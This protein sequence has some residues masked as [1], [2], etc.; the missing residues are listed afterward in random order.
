MHQLSDPMAVADAVAVPTL[1]INSRDDPICADESID[2]GLLR[3]PRF[4]HATTRRGSHLAFFHG[5]WAES[6][7]ERA[8]LQFLG[9]AL[10][11]DASAHGRWRQGASSLN[12]SH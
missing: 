6:W 11:R 8:A 4:I 9:L 3:N 2:A 10:E 5:L 12:V 1:L 7:A